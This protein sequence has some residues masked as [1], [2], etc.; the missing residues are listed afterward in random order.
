[1][2]NHSNEVL[3]TKT[4]KLFIHWYLSL[5]IT[6]TII[7]PCLL[8]IGNFNELI[9]WTKT[10]NITIFTCVNFPRPAGHFH[11]EWGSSSS[12]K[13]FISTLL[14]TS[15]ASCVSLTGTFS[16]PLRCEVGF[17]EWICDSIGEM[18][19]ISVLLSWSFSGVFSALIDLSSGRRSARC[20]SAASG[21]QSDALEILLVN[22]KSPTHLQ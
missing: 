10:V 3:N 7:M 20:T 16:D 15:S 19:Q 13:L 1:M 22:I 17:T 21:G 18:T 12:A 6:T 11:I 14:F 8:G 9:W 2:C 5:N 4:F